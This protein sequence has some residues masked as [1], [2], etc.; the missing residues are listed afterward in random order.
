QVLGAM[1][2][3]GQLPDLAGELLGRLLLL[4][5]RRLGLAQLVLQPGDRGGEGGGLAL[6]VRCHDEQRTGQGRRGHRG[7]GRGT[8]AAGGGE[9]VRRRARGHATAC[10]AG[11]RPWPTSPSWA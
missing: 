10:A 5:D 6:V 3:A 9:G 8:V 7:A 2:G 4:G 1:E 11:G